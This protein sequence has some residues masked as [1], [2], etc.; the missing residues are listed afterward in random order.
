MYKKAA[1]A[2]ILAAVVIVAIALRKQMRWATIVNRFS[3]TNTL[4]APIDASTLASVLEAAA[5][6]PAPVGTAALLRPKFTHVTLALADG[7]RVQAR[8]VFYEPNAPEGP[9]MSLS[10]ADFLHSVMEDPAAE[11]AALNPGAAPEL[12]ATVERSQIPRLLA[13]L[14]RRGFRA[15]VPSAAP[16]PPTV[17]SE[18]GTWQVRLSEVPAHKKSAVIDA[19]R[20]LSGKGPAETQVLVESAPCVVIE[21]ISAKDS[22]RWFEALIDAGA[23]G[24]RMDA[25]AG[26]AP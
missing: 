6:G 7:R 25:S 8:P 24:S 21:G 17:A 5:S 10:P 3:A 1:V 23:S 9:I 19:L 20:R 4:V 11:A 26:S 15:S 13:S 16:E 14:E 12:T 22:R 2:A 18:P